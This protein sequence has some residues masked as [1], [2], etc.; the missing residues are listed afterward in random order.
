V[1]Q[2]YRRVRALQLGRS[3]RARRQRRDRAGH[4]FTPVD[5]ANDPFWQKV[6]E[7]ID[8]GSLATGQFGWTSLSRY[9]FWIDVPLSR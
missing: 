9:K 8:D 2:P 6:D 4:L 7:R 3:S 1:G 5:P